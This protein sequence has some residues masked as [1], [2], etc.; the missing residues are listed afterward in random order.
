M[1]ENNDLGNKV[2]QL[3]KEKGYTQGQLAKL[4]GTD[5]KHISKIEN[6]IHLPTYK[7]LKK[8]S[9]VLNFNLKD[10]NSISVKINSK[11][12]NPIYNKILKIL[13]SAK[14]EKELNNY[15]NAL[16]MTYKLMNGR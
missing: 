1:N 9:E 10:M 8:L 5:D 6:G 3:R 4:I 13:N 12:Q 7:T 11:M 14:N 16:K 2:R 15:Y